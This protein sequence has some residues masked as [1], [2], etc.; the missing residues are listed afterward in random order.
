[1]T[2]IINSHSVVV[3]DVFAAKLVGVMTAAPSDD[4]AA[5]V[6]DDVVEWVFAIGRFFV[7]DIDVIVV[8]DEECNTSVDSFSIGL[9]IDDK[10]KVSWRIF[11][12]VT[13]TVLTRSKV[14]PSYTDLAVFVRS[15][16]SVTKINIVK[17]TEGGSNGAM[18]LPSMHNS[19]HWWMSFLIVFAWRQTSIGRTDPV[20][21]E[22]AYWE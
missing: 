16:G 9:K 2:M 14:S 21:I 4:F 8:V 11:H 7:D 1:M 20:L 3:S 13:N 10:S 18:D 17:V 22:M 19:F 12:E 6:D 5:R 15:N